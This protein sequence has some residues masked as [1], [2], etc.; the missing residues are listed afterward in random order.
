MRRSARLTS[1][2]ARQLRNQQR[3]V[4][5]SPLQLLGS[6]K[7]KQGAS[8]SEG[9]RKASSPSW[10]LWSWA[11]DT[12]ARL[13]LRTDSEL[14]GRSFYMLVW[15]YHNSGGASDAMAAQSSD[16]QRPKLLEDVSR[17]SHLNS[18]VELRPVL[19]DSQQ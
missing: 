2:L 10:R 14:L 11:S 8:S 4:H 12:Q 13:R 3:R 15:R 1:A 5:T 16:W 9:L 7:A 19:L 6:I 18:I 17:A